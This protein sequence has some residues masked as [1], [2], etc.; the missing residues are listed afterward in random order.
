MA[1]AHPLVYHI[2]NTREV[3]NVVDIEASHVLLPSNPGGALPIR[4]WTASMDILSLFII[5][6]LTDPKSRKSHRRQRGRIN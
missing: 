4:V 2:A 1:R 5:R 6:R 3:R